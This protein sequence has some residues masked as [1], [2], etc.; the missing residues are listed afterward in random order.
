EVAETNFKESLKLDPNNC[1]AAFYLGKIFGDRQEWA[2]SG[3]YYER[4]A[5][6]HYGKELAF[7]RK[8]AE[9]EGSDFSEERKQKMIAKKKVQLKNTILTK[10]TFF[11][12]AAAGYFNAE[13]DDQALKLAEQAT[14]HITLKQKAEELILKIKER[15]DGKRNLFLERSI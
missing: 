14:S 9:I 10:A 2:R 15:K 11:Y 1:E 5:L 7:E 8:I 4:A 12:N 6:C 3:E 13:M